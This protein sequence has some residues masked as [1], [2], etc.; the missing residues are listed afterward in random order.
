MRLMP[1]GCKS[2]LLFIFALDSTYCRFNFFSFLTSTVN[3]EYLASQ[4][5]ACAGVRFL[6]FCFFPIIPLITP[7]G[8]CLKLS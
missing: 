1:L 8:P 4:L 7:S 2:V 3:G 5:S 6:L